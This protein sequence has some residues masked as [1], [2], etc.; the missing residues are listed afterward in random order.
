MNS[1]EK[2]IRL[3]S[4]EG[5]IDPGLHA[6][7]QFVLIWLNSYSQSFGILVLNLF[8]Q[9]QKKMKKE[10][11]LKLFHQMMKISTKVLLKKG[12]KI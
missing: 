10:I 4:E 12:M 8:Y 1:G 11:A 7:P 9:F 6:G 3:K 5:N 2:L